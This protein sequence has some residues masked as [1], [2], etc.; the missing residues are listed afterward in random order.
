[1][2]VAEQEYEQGEAVYTSTKISSLVF[3]L[4]GIGLSVAISMAIIKSIRRSI[5]HASDV[6][7][8]LAE[9]DLTV[10]MQAK[11]HDEIGLLL[12]DLK[13]MIDKTKQVIAYVSTA[14]DHIVAAGQE[15]S[16]SSQ[17]MSEGA[18]EQAAATEQ[19]SSSMEEMVANVHQNSE[20]AVATKKIAIK[21]S[22]DAINGSAAVQAAATSIKS[23]ADKINVISEIARQTNILALNAAVEAARAGDQG[24]GFAVVAAEVRKL[25]EKS[26]IAATEIIELSRSGVTIAEKSGTLLELMVPDIEQTARLVEEISASSLEQNQGAEQINDAMQQLNQVTQQNAA[27]SEEMAASAEE[28]SAQA[29]QLRDIISFFKL[30]DELRPGK[31]RTYK[32]SAGKAKGYTAKVNT[33]NA[34]LPKY[35]LNG[36]KINMDTLD[37]DYEK[38]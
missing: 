36:V 26:Q 12:N 27:T 18:T 24:R 37:D 3:I 13:S 7:S 21:A 11:S 17:Q 5:S 30:D 20:N 4:L 25:A 34:R 31:F 28:L 33:T 14:S 8:K 38:Y 22:V 19:V 1:M 2:R 15:L 29:E 32:E 6:I 10:N 23:I 35:K 9:G 16:S